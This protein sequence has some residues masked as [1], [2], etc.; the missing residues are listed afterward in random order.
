MNQE[1][2]TFKTTI[3]VSLE[4]FEEIFNVPKTKE[5]L[6][7]FFEE[8]DNANRLESLTVRFKECLK[9]DLPE[10]LMIFPRKSADETINTYAKYRLQMGILNNSFETIV[11]GRSIDESVQKEIEKQLEEE[12]VFEELECFIESFEEENE[13]ISMIESWIAAMLS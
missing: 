13:I 6:D 4:R 10:E 12:T 7:K 5:L 3:N 11:N 1:M 8:E 9:G 2:I